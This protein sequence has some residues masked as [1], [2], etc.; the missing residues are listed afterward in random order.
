MIWFLGIFGSLDLRVGNVYLQLGLRVVCWS[1]RIVGLHL[2]L[3]P[4]TESILLDIR[5]RGQ[6][7]ISSVYGP[8]SPRLCSLM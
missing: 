7:W 4:L 5:G 2:R 1:F 3:N 6:W 8:N